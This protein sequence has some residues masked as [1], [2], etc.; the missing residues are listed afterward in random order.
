[1][2][3][4]VEKDLFVSV[5]YKGTLQNGDV[6]DTSH[7]H[8]PLEVKV[9]AGQ[10]ISGFENELLGMS[11][12][13]KK[14]FTL[15]PA[16]AYGNRNENLKRDIP[17]ADFPPELNPRVG[18]TVGLQNPEGHQVPAQIVHLDDEKL[19]LDMN[20]PLAGKT[21]NFEIEVVGISDTQTQAPSGCGCGC[22]CSQD[23]C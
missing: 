17:K 7:G 18:M 8:Q 2:V 22:D 10:L 14:T 12:N 3:K 1:M 16:E 13:E 6:F 4:K 20:H 11:L 9:G 5:D 23:S 21:L 19:T 15:E